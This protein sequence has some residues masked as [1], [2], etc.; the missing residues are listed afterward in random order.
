M[1]EYKQTVGPEFYEERSYMVC[2]PIAEYCKVSKPRFK[3]IFEYGAVNT[4]PKDIRVVE[5]FAGVGGFRIGLERASHR[6]KT[7]WNNQ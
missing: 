6:F 5:L 2:E 7:I 4:S 1:K 3:S